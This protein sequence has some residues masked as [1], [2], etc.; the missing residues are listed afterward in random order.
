MKTLKKYIAHKQMGS[1]ESH[2][3]DIADEEADM[4]PDGKHGGVASALKSVLREPKSDKNRV[5]PDH[6]KLLDMEDDEGFC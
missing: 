2:T 5:N 6:A 4:L 3:A 1:K